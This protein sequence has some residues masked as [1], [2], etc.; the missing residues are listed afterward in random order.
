MQLTQKSLV[1]LLS[2]LLVIS[3]VA[4]VYSFSVNDEKSN[5][6]QSQLAKYERGLV[7]KENERASLQEELKAN[8]VT[9]PIQDEEVEAVASESEIEPDKRINT[10]QRFI[11]Y[12]FETRPETYATRKKLALNYMTTSLFETLYSSDG[13]DEE[14]QK[15]TVTIKEATV[16]PNNQDEKEAIVFYTYEEKILSSGYNEQKEMYVKLL[17]TVEDNQLKVAEIE[18]LENEYGGI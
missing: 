18:P 1:I 17:F 8:E 16:F 6:A 11:E 5:K 10:A 13:I 4:N 12:A 7:E 2:F 9:A 3:L 14:Q 15:I